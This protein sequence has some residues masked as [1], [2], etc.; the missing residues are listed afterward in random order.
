MAR[1]L[2]PSAVLAVI[3]SW[4]S[5][6]HQEAVLSRWRIFLSPLIDSLV[7]CLL[8]ALLYSVRSRSQMKLQ[9]HEQLSHRCAMA[10]SIRSRAECSGWMCS[11]EPLSLV[12]RAPRGESHDQS[13]GIPC[14]DISVRPDRFRGWPFPFAKRR[15]SDNLGI[16]RRSRSTAGGLSFVPPRRMAS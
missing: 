9:T 4:Q 6:K 12:T 16:F 1:I 8:I 3:V 14:R 2:M 11:G 5:C 13:L 7:R 10:C 15:R